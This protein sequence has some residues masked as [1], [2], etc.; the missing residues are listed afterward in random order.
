MQCRLRLASSLCRRSCRSPCRPS[1]RPAAAALQIEA[2]FV[3][4]R[5][6]I[7]SSLQAT[8]EGSAWRAQQGAPPPPLHASSRMRASEDVPPADA[9]VGAGHHHPSG[10]GARKTAAARGKGRASARGTSVESLHS[11]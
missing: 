8:G 10:H 3:Q 2:Q 6:L 4:L 1:L 7:Q 11:V 5:E 9:D